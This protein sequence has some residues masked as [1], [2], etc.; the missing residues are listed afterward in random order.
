MLD[1]RL[2]FFAG[3]LSASAA[4]QIE[5][6]FRYP[7]QACTSSLLSKLVPSS[8]TTSTLQRAARITSF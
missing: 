5:N 4:S 7:S 8:L 3:C 2:P 1:T 6:P